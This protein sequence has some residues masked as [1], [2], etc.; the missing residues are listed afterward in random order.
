MRYFRE[1][2]RKNKYW[3]LFYIVLCLNASFM[4]S[5]KASYFQQ[6]I[7]GFADGTLA[8]HAILIYGAILLWCALTSYLGELPQNKLDNGI[9]LDFKLTA[10]RKI[11]RMDYETYRAAGTGK[12]MQRIENGAA[13]GKSIL[14][15][16]WFT[17]LGS[18][19]PTIGFSIVFIWQINRTITYMILLGYVG[20][21]IVTNL[22][23]KALY[24]IKERVLECEEQMNHFLVRGFME[25]LVFRMERQFPFEIRKASKAKREIVNSKTKMSMI[26]EAFFVLFAVLVIFLDVGI[27]MYA[28]NSKAVSVGEAVALIS[29]IDNAYTPIAIFNV[30]FVQYK[31]DKAAYARLEAFLDS[32]DD[33]QLTQ[34]ETADAAGDIAV[35]NLSFRYGERAI[36]ENLNLRIQKGEKVAFVGESGSGKTT[37]LR[38]L[39]GLTKY[40][41]GSVRINGQELKTLCLDSLYGQ[42]FYVSQDSPVFDGTLRENMVFDR[43]VPDVELWAALGAVQLS[44]MAEKLPEGLDTAVGERGAGLSGGEKQRLALSRLCFSHRPVV[45]LDEATSAMDNLTEKAVMQTVLHEAEGSTL[46]AV[47]HRLNAVA[48]FDR[49][50]VFHRGEIVGEGSFSELMEKNTYFQSLYRALEQEN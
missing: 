2:L 34:R 39:A 20:V 10:L 38:I 16:F 45:L 5:F 19:L 35:Q 43:A 11:S 28:Y 46:I 32:P 47:A 12:V 22:L 8:F 42:L 40:E 30:V 21:F 48:D 26:H 6:V 15:G 33:P 41:N 24:K 25:M 3:V 29:L 44:F 31:L 7:D 36:F 1:I 9:L 17:F 13:A 50:V 14:F 49:I 4:S 23:L 27:L 37:L 18:L